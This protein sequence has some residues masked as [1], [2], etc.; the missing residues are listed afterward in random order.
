MIRAVVR[1]ANRIVVLFTSRNPIFLSS[2]GKISIIAHS[3]G[4]TLITD[5]LSIQPTFVK[6]LNEMTIEEKRNED[7]FVFDTRCLFL[8]GSPL[9][10]FI[11]LQKSQLIA[12]AGRARSKN[13]GKDIALDRTKYGCMSIDSIYNIYFETD[14]VAFMLNVTVSLLSLSSSFS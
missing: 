1:E 13:V 4:S 8:V 2:G 7:H 5:I 12:R 6:S 14:P 11:H 10:F 3:L 9:A